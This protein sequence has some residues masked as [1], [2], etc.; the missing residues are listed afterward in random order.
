MHNLSAALSRGKMDGPSSS[1]KSDP[2]RQQRS[3]T[4]RNGYVAR[5]ITLG[6]LLTLAACNK[7]G[8]STDSSASGASSAASGASA[9][10]AT[11]APAPAPPV[12]IP[13]QTS[14]TVTVDQNIS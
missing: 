4:M 9:A 11:P 8:T 6:I 5:F 13:A 10:S 12:V 7:T 1:L 14:L 3:F 2:H